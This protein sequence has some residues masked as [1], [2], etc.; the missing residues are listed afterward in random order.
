MLLS[1]E[2]KLCGYINDNYFFLKKKK[3]LVKKEKK[4][5]VMAESTFG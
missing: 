5:H 3:N 4:T 2:N 1:F